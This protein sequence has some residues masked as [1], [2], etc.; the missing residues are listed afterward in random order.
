MAAEGKY[1]NNPRDPGGETVWGIARN[2]IK[3]WPFWPRW[4]QLKKSMGWT[5]A[6]EA[7]ET[8][9]A[10]AYWYQNA[11]DGPWVKVR[12][13]DISSQWIADELFDTATNTGPA[14]AAAFLQRTLNV[15]NRSDLAGAPLWE[16]LEV[17]GGIGPKTLGAL[18]AALARGMGPAVFQYLNALQGAFYIELAEHKPKFEAFVRGW[19]LRLAD[20]NMKEFR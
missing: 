12:G 14:V 15:L 5:A 7:P 3:D 19:A 2:R 8:L 16:E 4:D 20:R 17:K 9:A 6:S 11:P 13:S 18:R 1:S 10:V